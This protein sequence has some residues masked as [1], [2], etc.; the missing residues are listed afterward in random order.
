M[1]D[2]P[3]DLNDYHKRQSAR[4]VKEVSE[5]PLMS[6]EE[7]I[8]QV[9]RLSSQSRKLKTSSGESTKASVH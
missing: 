2:K 8:K 5:Q 6:P 4:L 1:S 7:S 9:K 3:I